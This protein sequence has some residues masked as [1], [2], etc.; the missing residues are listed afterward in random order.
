MSKQKTAENASLPTD[1][2]VAVA[3][4]FVWV[5]TSL[6]FSLKTVMLGAWCWSVYGDAH[7]STSRT[8]LLRAV[9][10]SAVFVVG[11]GVL[12]FLGGD[13]ALGT[14]V[15]HDAFAVQEWFVAAAALLLRRGACA[16]SA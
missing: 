10:A 9:A 2:Q 1:P 7:A 11:L 12:A 6:F 15:E 14:R 4:V 8:Y 3:T 5:G 16:E 13:H